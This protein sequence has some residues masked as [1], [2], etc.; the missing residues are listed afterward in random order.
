MGDGAGV[1]T[2]REHGDGHY[3]AD[4]FAERPRL[5]DGVHRLAEQ[6][7]V[8]D[9]VRLGAVAGSEKALAAEPLYLL[10]GDAP[11]IGGERVSAFELLAVYEQRPRSGAA[12]TVF[13]EVVE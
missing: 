13:A 4:G 1:P 5:A 9:G 12:R 10:G 2:L 7:L 8:G 11:E 6:V 3:A